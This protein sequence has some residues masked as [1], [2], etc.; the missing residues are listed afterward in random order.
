MPQKTLV[1]LRKNLLLLRKNKQKNAQKLKNTHRISNTASGHKHCMLYD[2][3]ARSQTVVFMDYLLPGEPPRR[4]PEGSQRHP[5]V[6]RRPGL[7]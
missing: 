4:H 5:E 2:P 7:S 3:S 6:P 1:L